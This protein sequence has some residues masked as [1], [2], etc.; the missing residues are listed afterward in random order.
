[1]AIT[2]IID[3]DLFQI[4]DSAYKSRQEWYEKLENMDNHD[5][6]T[7]SRQNP[8]R[9]LQLKSILVTTEQTRPNSL[10]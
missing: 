6:D 9:V 4:I 8:T 5:I 10:D 7:H 3:D 1:M 2:Y